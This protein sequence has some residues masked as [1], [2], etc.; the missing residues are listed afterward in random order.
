MKFFSQVLEYPIYCII[1]IASK[2]TIFNKIS[3]TRKV[4]ILGIE[5]SFSPKIHQLLDKW[6]FTIN[7]FQSHKI[8]RFRVYYGGQDF[9][10]RNFN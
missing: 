6:L 1:F 7:A 8:P 3:Q 5:E 4:R 2:Q 9:A 10:P